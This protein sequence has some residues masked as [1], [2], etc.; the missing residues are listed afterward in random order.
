MSSVL[1]DHLIVG[2]VETVLGNRV[3]S[4][5][6]GV[7][8]WPHLRLAEAGP[9]RR[10][11]AEA[12]SEIDK[13]LARNDAVGVGKTTLCIYRCRESEIRGDDR[14]NTNNETKTAT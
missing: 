2:C 5:R 1:A 14:R 6:P 12:V 3:R 7:N 4:L 10:V 8:G 13:L 9:D 11:W